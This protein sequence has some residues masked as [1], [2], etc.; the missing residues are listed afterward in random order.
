MG[1]ESS[2]ISLVRRQTRVVGIEGAL[3]DAAH[4]FHGDATRKLERA[5]PS[6]WDQDIDFSNSDRPRG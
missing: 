5:K 1:G 3:Q 2:S 4:S 6:A